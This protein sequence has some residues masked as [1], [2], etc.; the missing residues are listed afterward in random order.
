MKN[1]L[2]KFL[3][4][5]SLIV[6][7]GK[8]LLNAQ[9]SII[10]YDPPISFTHLDLWHFNIMGTLDT[11]M[12]Q[13][14]VAV[15][16]F[17]GQG[18]LLVKSQ[19]ADFQLVTSNLYVA[20]TNLGPLSPLTISY[21]VDGFYANI[22]NS[23]GQ[24]PAGAYQIDYI[25]YGRPTDGEFSELATYSLTANVE[26]LFPPLLIS[27]E[28]EDTI[29]EQYPVFTWTP[30]VQ[31]SPGADLTYYFKM[32][33]VTTFQSSYQA[34]T[35]NPFYYSLM[36]IPITMLNYPTSAATLIFGQQYAWQIDA[37]IN[38]QVAASSE[39]WTFVYGCPGDTIIDSIPKL[40][41]VKLRNEEYG[42]VAKLSNKFL[43]INYSA[44]YFPGENAH[45]K[46]KVYNL[47]TNQVMPTNNTVLDVFEGENNYIISTCGDGLN[48][49]DGSY[50]FEVTDQKGGRWYMQFTKQNIQCN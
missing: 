23:G 32:V 3:F 45:L 6:L 47:I 48:L 9:Y 19:S 22:V 27:V 34:I 36:E 21:T 49:D 11:T 4:A 43:Y 15:R 26:S 14:Y 38:N 41:Y 16:I 40:P 13:Y 46:Y 8:S 31:A 44:R 30:A 25:L 35:S 18:T 20:P 37:M 7:P 10:A 33:E 12:V 39:I 1:T 24:F 42:G 17:D 5:T 2:L 29:C 28:N 50:L